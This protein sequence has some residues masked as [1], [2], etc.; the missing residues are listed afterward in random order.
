MHDVYEN[1][2][3]FV[4]AM[5]DRLK[6]LVTQD[7]KDWITLQQITGGRL[8]SVRQTLEE[9]AIR[10]SRIHFGNS[11]SHRLEVAPGLKVIGVSLILKT[12]SHGEIFDIVPKC[13]FTHGSRYLE[14]RLEAIPLGCWNVYDLYLLR[15][16]TQPRIQFIARSSDS[17]YLSC[18]VHV[19]STNNTWTLQSPLRIAYSRAVGLRLIDPIDF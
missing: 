12:S 17:G 13:D 1:N 4:L 3:V 11:L 6:Q 8:S 5:L 18:N 10:N 15:S 2:R 16:V 7:C 9:S 14:P 19:M